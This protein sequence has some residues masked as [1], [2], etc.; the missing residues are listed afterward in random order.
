VGRDEAVTVAL[1]VEVGGSASR[2]AVMAAAASSDAASKAACQ[3][4]K[5]LRS[6]NR[7]ASDAVVGPG[8]PLLYGNRSPCRHSIPTADRCAWRRTFVRM[9]FVPLDPFQ[10]YGARLA[11]RLLRPRT[12]WKV[13]PN[14]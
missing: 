10:V 3:T 13:I 6:G 7:S 11:G 14:G 8:M 2:R 9:M 1:E 12:I 4:Y 5:V